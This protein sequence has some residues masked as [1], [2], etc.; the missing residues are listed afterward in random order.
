MLGN[1]GQE[2]GTSLINSLIKQHKF[3]K[4]LWLDRAPQ[5]GA[6]IEDFV[7][8]HSKLCEFTLPTPELECL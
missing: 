7:H 6:A 5:V 2:I 8:L 3:M 4:K 1:G